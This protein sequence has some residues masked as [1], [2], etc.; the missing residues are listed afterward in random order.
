MIFILVIYQIAANQDKPSTNAP[1]FVTVKDKHLKS[2]N[3]GAP[4]KRRKK[5]CKLSINLIA[6][7]LI[8]RLWVKISYNFISAK[9][10]RI[11]ILAVAN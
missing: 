3:A 7:R 2:S 9:T 6:L 5:R 11:Q 4:S 10:M 8:T 1:L